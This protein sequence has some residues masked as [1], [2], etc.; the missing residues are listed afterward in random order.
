MALQLRKK[1]T[2]REF[3]RMKFQILI[4]YLRTTL[5]NGLGSKLWRKWLRML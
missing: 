4:K 2:S 5:K 1:L 3:I